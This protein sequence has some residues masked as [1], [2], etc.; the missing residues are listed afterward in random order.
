MSLDNHWKIWATPNVTGGYLETRMFFIRVGV[1]P[2][3]WR[4]IVG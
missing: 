1:G 3:S 2:I 4:I